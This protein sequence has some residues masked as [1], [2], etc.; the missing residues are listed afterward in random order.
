M[1]NCCL[2]L[3][4]FSFGGRANAIQVYETDKAAFLS[5]GGALYFESFEEAPLPDLSKVATFGDVTVS[6]DD[7]IFLERRPDVTDGHKALYTS[8]ASDVTFTFDHPIF[9]FGIDALDV[10]DF[11]P[12]TLIFSNSNGL[13]ALYIGVLPGYGKSL[14]GGLIDTQG[15]TSLTIHWSVAGESVDYDSL[16]FSQAPLAVPGVPEPA[17]WALML[18][19]FGLAGAT[20][21]RRKRQHPSYRSQARSPC[22]PLA[23]RP[24]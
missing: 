24:A 5:A 4:T 17:T 8:T 1:L 14:F 3:A 22:R 19:G 2:V 23:A 18:S 16:Y 21:R 6:S 15:F 20:L 12:Q 10:G 13:G 7:Y 11:G 9:A